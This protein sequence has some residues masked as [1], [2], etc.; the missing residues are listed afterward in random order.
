MVSSSQFS[1]SRAW[2]ERWIQNIG[3]VKVGEVVDGNHEIV[4]GSINLHVF[5]DTE[6]S[7]FVEEM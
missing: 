7:W 5:S 2:H 4:G 3:N 6:Q 1:I